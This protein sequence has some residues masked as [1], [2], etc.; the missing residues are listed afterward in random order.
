MR[1]KAWDF[2]SAASG[3]I[4]LI[5]KYNRTAPHQVSADQGPHRR[6][7]QLLG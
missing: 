2:G 5:A 3:G 4:T 6:D 1:L 7:S